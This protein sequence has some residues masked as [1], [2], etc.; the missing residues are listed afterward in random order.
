MYITI[1]C[2]SFS[3][4][5]PNTCRTSALVTP[6]NYCHCNERIST[7]I[8]LLCHCVIIVF[9]SFFLS[10]RLSLSLHPSIPPQLLERPKYC[11]IEKIKT[12]GSTYMAACGLTDR[13][14]SGNQAVLTMARFAHDIQKKLD[15]IN[16]HSFNDFKLK[17]GKI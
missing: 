15:M 3:T 13:D 17:I 6:S 11:R 1:V 14:E 7:Y 16:K 9:L 4:V 12:I 5:L 10:L 8:Y 2:V